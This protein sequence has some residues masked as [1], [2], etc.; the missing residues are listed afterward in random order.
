M[1][2]NQLITEIIPHFFLYYTSNPQLRASYDIE[3]KTISI[4]SENRVQGI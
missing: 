3:A 2:F 4:N 1:C